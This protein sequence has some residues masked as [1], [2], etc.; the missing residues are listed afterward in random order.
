[1]PR[2]IVLDPIAQEGLKLLDDAEQIE[3]EVRTDLTPRQLRAVLADFDGAICRSGAQLTAEALADNPRLRA[4]VRAGVGTD[5]IDKSIATRLG[6]VVMN[7]PTGN[8][9]STAEHTFA[10]MLALSRQVAPAYQ[11]LIAGCWDRKTYVGSQLAD[12]TLGVVGLGKIGQ[13]VARR[14]Q[15]FQM[16]VL[17]YDPFV[18]PKQASKLGIDMVEQVAEMLP[19]VDYL[20]VH[21]PLTEATHHL[22]GH[23]E[24]SLLRPGVRLINCARGGIYDESAL[25]A[26][27]QS[28]RIAGVALDVFE[29][30]PCSKSP[31]FGKPGVLCTPHLG[32]STAE[33]QTRVAVEAVNLLVNYLLTGEVRHAVNTAA[34]DPGILDSLRGYLDV[35][36]RLGLLLSQWHEGGA[37]SCTLRYRGEVTQKDTRLLTAAFCTGLLQRALDEEVNLVNA[38]LLFRERG[39]ELSEQSDHEMGAF[40]SSIGAQLRT[41][42]GSFRVAGTLFGNQMPRLISLG[43]YRLE[44]YLDGVLLLFSHTD[45]PGIIGTVG[46]ICGK[47]DLNIAQMSVGRAADKPGGGAIGVLNL[48]TIPPPAAI[49]EILAHQAIHRA[50]VIELPRSDERPSWLA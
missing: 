35:S 29:Q 43:E 38:E 28:G 21:T 23:R 40:S 20:T 12:K 39:L 41:S 14:A 37:Q 25:L 50:K 42:S 15:A 6:I 2:V 30:E 32:A 26:G 36:H 3:Y 17:G 34:I 13:E 5:N 8:T 1:M 49:D 11:S 10:L 33:A 46:T 7:S 22:I 24:L 16:H 27:L 45:V 18:A 9:L 31:L 48:E 4:I 44:A 47:Y 19:E